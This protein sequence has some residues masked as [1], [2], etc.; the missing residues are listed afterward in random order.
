MVATAAISYDLEKLASGSRRQVNND[1]A[2]NSRTTLQAELD[3]AQVYSEE[4]VE[5]V[6]A[7]LPGVGRTATGSIRSWTPAWRST[8]SELDEDG[9]VEFKGGAKA[10]ART[11]AFLSSV[12][13]YTNAEWAKRSIFLRLLILKLPFGLLSERDR[14]LRNPLGGGAGEGTRGISLEPLVPRYPH[15]R[16]SSGRS[17][18]AGGEASAY[19]GRGPWWNAGESHMN[20]ALPKRYFAEHGLVSLLLQHRRWQV[21]S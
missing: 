14:L 16:V 6:G 4:E 12:L 21:A 7:A 20:A 15:L 3:H 2:L 10:F 5:G 8:G 19:N 13:P 9:Q 18:N 11:Y 1:G 17:P